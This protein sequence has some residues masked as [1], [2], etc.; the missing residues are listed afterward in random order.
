MPEIKV[1]IWFE[2][3]GGVFFGKGRYELLKMIDK[4]G[5]LKLAAKE[6]HM[7]YRAAWGKIK[8]TEEILGKPLIEKTSNKEGYHLTPLGRFCIEEFES[9]YKDVNDYCRERSAKMITK[10]KNFDL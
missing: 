2:K 4:V 7:S 6:L 8:K 3:E 9:V 1:H 10:I 5:N